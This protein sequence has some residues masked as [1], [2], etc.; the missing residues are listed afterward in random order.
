MKTAMEAGSIP[1]AMLRSGRVELLLETRLPD[2]A[3][4][5]AILDERLA[6][7]TEPIWSADTALLASASHG[8]TG[9]DLKAVMEDG[10]LPS[11][12]DRARGRNP[13]AVETAPF[14]FAG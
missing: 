1:A 7:L 6:R 12:H 13:R 10:K 14:G 11:D 4:R 5:K 9:A 8:L 3:A 2:P